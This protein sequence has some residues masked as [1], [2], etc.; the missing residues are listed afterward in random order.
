MSATRIFDLL[1]QYVEKYPSQDVAL[2]GK[3]N[4]VWVKYSIQEYATKVDTIS[5]AL[6]AK[7]VKMGDKV[8]I[9]SGNRPE[10]N[11]F[12]MAIMQIACVC[13]PIYPTISDSDYLH[14]LNHAEIEYLFVDTKDLVKKLKPIITQVPH[15]KEIICLEEADNTILLETFYK[16]GE[17]HPNPEELKKRKDY[18][19]PTDLATMIYTSGTTGMPKGVMLSHNNLLS[20]IHALETI[21]APWSKTALSFLPLCHAYER[22]LVYLYHHMGM[23]VYYA[24]NLGTIAEN[25]KEVQPTMMS[26]VPR[27]LEKIYDKLYM[28]GKKMEGLK[29]TLYYWAF[30]LAKN[31]RIDQNSPWYLLKHQIADKLIYSKWREAIGGNFDIIVSGGAAIQKQ[32]AAFFN[33]IGMPVFEGY[34]LSE[35]SPVIA[36]SQRG[37]GQR[38]AGTVGPALPGVEIRIGA[39]NEIQCK[40]PNVMMG[41][42][43]DGELTAEVIDPEGWF[44]T[45]DTGKFEK[46]NLI[47]TGRLK[48]IFKTSFGKYVNPFLIEEQFCKS[49]FIE[50]MVVFGENQKFAAALILPDFVYLKDYCTRHNITFTDNQSLISNTEVQTIFN[51]EV[52]KYNPQFA[53]HEQIKSYE[54]IADE[55]SMANGL[56][57]PTLKVKRNVIEE[58][59]KEQIAKLFA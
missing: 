26:C 37:K 53:H 29:K 2:A 50:N 6:M 5:Y 46:G 38:V 31:Y 24:E 39:N 13:V 21:P 28:S 43:R 55:W 58:L 12:D 17:D 14:I 18:V 57:T 40:G 54:L 8:G 7:G 15:F 47:I 51:K 42:Y 9:V 27:L 23:S 10:W 4:K 41:Y 25:I 45:G 36:V 34:G 49:P 16:L 52:K 19:L 33:A 35:T 59:Y 20:Q 56:L 32:Q 22:I 30:E 1:S 44:H 48:N 3:T 11:F